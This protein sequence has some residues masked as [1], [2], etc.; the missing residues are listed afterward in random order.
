MAMWRTTVRVAGRQTTRR[1]IR[2]KRWSAKSSG[3]SWCIKKW[4]IEYWSLQDDCQPASYHLG[5]GP[6]EEVAG[7]L[8]L[9]AQ[10]LWGRQKPA[11]VRLRK[12]PFHSHSETSWLHVVFDASHGV[13]IWRVNLKRKG[14]DIVP[15]CIFS[16]PK[17]SEEASYCLCRWG[18]A[19]GCWR[20]WGT[21]WLASGKQVGPQM[22]GVGQWGKG[23]ILCILFW[24]YWWAF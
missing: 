23:G 11:W 7:R 10:T 3:N 9:W 14:W 13:E 16:L 22:V 12:A 18:Q 4:K 21:N 19:K 8:P 6:A 5:W 15:E 2:V 20:P 17:K 24:A 1:K